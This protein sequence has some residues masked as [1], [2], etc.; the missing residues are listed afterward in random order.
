M[1]ASRRSSFLLLK[2]RWD[3]LAASSFRRLADLSRRGWTE[4]PKAQKTATLGWPNAFTYGAADL[5]VGI[6]NYENSQQAEPRG[7]G[8]IICGFGRR[9]RR[10]LLLLR[11]ILDGLGDR[12]LGLSF[13]LDGLSSMACTQG[14]AVII[15]ALPWCCPCSLAAYCAENAIPQMMMHDGKDIEDAKIAL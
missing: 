6:D 14:I 2:A 12:L 4:E 3:H 10:A 9:C 8:W 1:A 13:R 7:E 11:P 5:K 15:S